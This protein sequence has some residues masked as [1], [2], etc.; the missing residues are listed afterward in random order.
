MGGLEC[1]RWV[2]DSLFRK[3]MPPERDSML[4]KNFSQVLNIFEKDLSWVK[5]KIPG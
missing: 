1:V 4:R 5:V 2:E 3:T